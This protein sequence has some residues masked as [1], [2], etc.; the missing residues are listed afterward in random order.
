MYDPM[1]CFEKH[2]DNMEWSF[3]IKERIAIWC[4]SSPH[5]ILDCCLV[6]FLLLTT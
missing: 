2:F 3:L 1:L 5:S 6:Q 4:A